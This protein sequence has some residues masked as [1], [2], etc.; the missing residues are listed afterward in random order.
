L[1][2]PNFTQTPRIFISMQPDPGSG[3]PNLEFCS[4]VF[5][6]INNFNFIIRIGNAGNSAVNGFVILYWLAIQ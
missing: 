1:G 6:D 3:T 4:Y 5:D 2:T